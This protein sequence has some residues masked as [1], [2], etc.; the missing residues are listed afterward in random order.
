MR[1]PTIHLNGTAKVD[2]LNEHE[3]AIRAVSNAI[4]TVNLIT[5]HGRDYYPQG[6]EAYAEAR[7]EMNVRLDALRTV[8]DGLLVLWQ[9]IQAQGR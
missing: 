3:A 1:A 6:A 8:R 9:E 5:V 4:E 2:L 7:Q